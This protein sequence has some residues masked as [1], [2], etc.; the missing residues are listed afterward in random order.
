[1]DTLHK[2]IIMMPFNL[3]YKVAPRFELGLLFRIKQGYK[4]NLKNPNTYSEKIQWIKV[5]DKNPLMPKCVDKYT[6]R[7]Y[8][9]SK[10]C[11]EILNNLLWEGFDPEL[12]PFKELPRKFVIKVTHGSTFNI[13]CTDKESLDIDKV[14]RNLNKWLK[15]KFLPCYGEWFYGLEK[16]RIIIEEFIESCNGIKDYKVYCFNGEPKYIGV[17]GNRDN[18]GHN[19]T[20]ELYTIDWRIVNGKTGRLRDPDV[21][22]QKPKLLDQLIK[23][24]KILSK[25]FLHAR[26][27]F[28][29][30]NEKIYFGE[31]TFTSGAGFDRFSS[32]SFDLEFGNSL[33]LLNRKEK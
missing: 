4:L 32:Y 21:L 22:T 9:A 11:S 33:K 29:I 17:Y 24:S 10:N 16:P 26:V 13:I 25:D 14:K 1:M 5:N 6:V 15:A 28:F 2:N 19:P 31:I 18:K 27:D 7:E 23:Y 30:E 12:I 20:E 8:V 3:L